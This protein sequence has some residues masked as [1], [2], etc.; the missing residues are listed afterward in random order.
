MV[1]LVCF[2]LPRNT[3]DEKRQATRYQKRL[4]ELGF[5]MKQYSVYEREVRNQS[6]KERLLKTLREELP[7]SGSITIYQLPN[8]VNDNQ[9]TVLGKN[10]VMKTRRK[11]QI[12]FL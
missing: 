9:I 11:A 1:L 8:E 2:D 4:V 12:I 5:Y 7:D 6:T 10:C 3:K